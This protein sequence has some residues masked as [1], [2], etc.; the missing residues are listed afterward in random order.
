VQPSKITPRRTDPTG[1]AVRAAELIE[2]GDVHAA[3]KLLAREGDPAAQ[4]D[5]NEA[6]ARER[7]AVP[8]IAPRW[9]SAS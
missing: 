6:L 4:A 3:L 2:A 7:R 1:I 5:A 8:R 9:Q